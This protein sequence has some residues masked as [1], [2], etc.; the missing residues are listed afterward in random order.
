MNLAAPC[1]PAIIK[2]ESSGLESPGGFLCQSLATQHAVQLTEGAV[3]CK[4]G[5]SV[6]T[7]DEEHVNAWG[8]SSLY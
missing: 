1:S 3:E 5:A 7:W 8:W 4:A 2:A 6:E